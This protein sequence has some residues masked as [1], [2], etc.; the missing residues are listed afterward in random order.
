MN[1]YLSDVDRQIA[2]NQG[3]NF[4]FKPLGDLFQFHDQTKQ[5]LVEYSSRNITDE[6]YLIEYAVEKVVQEFCR[7]NQYYTFNGQAKSK[8]RN[9]YTELL[10]CIR[11][12][13]PTTEFNDLQPTKSI[14][15]FGWPNNTKEP[16]K[17]W[18]SIHEIE[19]RHFQKIR[20]WLYSTNPIAEQLYSTADINLKPVTCS[21][22]SAET[23]IDLLKIKTLELMEPLLD[24]GCGQH[25]HLVDHLRQNGIEAFGIDRFLSCKNNLE[26]HDWLEY[27]Y[28][29][30][31][32]GTIVSNIGFSNHFTHQNLLANGA[33]IKYAQTYK[34]ILNSLKIG[35]RFIY[36]PDL[37]F[38]ELYLDQQ[39]YSIVKYPIGNFKFKATAIIRLS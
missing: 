17:K 2:M 18:L 35:G 19:K 39:Q 34:Q 33:H 12:N 29:N 5:S 16:S 21:E 23:Q 36:A 28:G 1:E 11:N 4:F 24:I 37:P 38:I 10:S 20:R 22:Y 13:H 25:G 31:K 9:I 14:Q 26:Q 6:A 30:E 3:K 7:V 32:W 8:L 27:D 15:A